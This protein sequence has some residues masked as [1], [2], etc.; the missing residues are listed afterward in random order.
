[1]LTRHYLGEVELF[2]MT[3]WKSFMLTLP[4]LVPT[5]WLWFIAAPKNA[6]MAKITAMSCSFL[7]RQVDRSGSD[8]GDRSGFA[9]PPG[10]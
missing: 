6:S 3:K 7:V 2:L 8:D 9:C 1:M 5:A 10:G 4:A